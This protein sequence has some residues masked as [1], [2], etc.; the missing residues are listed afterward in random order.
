MNQYSYM[1][2]ILNGK[3]DNLMPLSIASND[4]DNGTN[5]GLK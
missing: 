2:K 5:K 4:I 1:C 3:F